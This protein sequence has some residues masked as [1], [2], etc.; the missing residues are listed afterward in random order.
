MICN[1]DLDRLIDKARTLNAKQIHI[2]AGKRP[3]LRLIDGLI[4][5]DDEDVAH[6]QDI[7]SLVHALLSNKQSDI[8]DSQGDIMFSLTSHQAVSCI[9]VKSIGSYTI[10]FKLQD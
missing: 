1:I 5:L 8:L 4:E 6:V 3:A 2:T 10:I 7:K 9:I